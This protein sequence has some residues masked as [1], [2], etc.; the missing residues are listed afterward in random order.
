[1]FSCWWGCAWCFLAVHALIG[2]TKDIVESYSTSSCTLQCNECPST[3]V[4]RFMLI[5]CCASL[6][7]RPY[8]AAIVLLTKFVDVWAR[9]ATIGWRTDRVH[10]LDLNFQDATAADAVS[11]CLVVVRSKFAF[12]RPWFK[13]YVEL[14]WAGCSAGPAP[15]P[16][17][18]DGWTVQDATK[19]GRGGGLGENELV[20]CS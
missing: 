17:A 14:D 18:N 1:M 11:L 10:A 5:C 16:G 3:Y 2:F 19:C 4:A 20:S 9:H 6:S 13:I 7:S 15:A 12:S 8:L